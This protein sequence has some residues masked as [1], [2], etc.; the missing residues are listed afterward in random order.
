MTRHHH[1]QGNPILPGWASGVVTVLLAVFVA[2][3]VWTLVD[4]NRQMRAYLEGLATQTTRVA[5]N[6]FASGD[7]FP[8]LQVHDLSAQ[9][10]NV[11]EL[12]P[13]GGFV[14]FVTTTCPYCELSLSQWS[15]LAGD[16]PVVGLS[17]DSLEETQAFATTHGIE[18]QL[19][20]LVASSEVRK[21]ARVSAVPL[22]ILIDRQGEI[23]Q[24]WQGVVRRSDLAAMQEWK[25]KV[26]SLSDA[27]PPAQ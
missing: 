15:E 20:S 3:T 18:W 1:R 16:A 2:A 23:A 21:E 24:T 19:V 9:Q 5:R 10:H 27:S 4:N 12:L 26:L 14:A 11:L 17:L 13:R 25:A 22:T 7:A 6:D 8:A